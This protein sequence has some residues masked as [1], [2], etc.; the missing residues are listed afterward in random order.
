MR[1]WAGLRIFSPEACVLLRE[2][3]IMRKN[4]KDATSERQMIGGDRVT[5]RGRGVTEDHSEEVAF[6]G[7]PESR[8]KTP[9]SPPTL[10]KDKMTQG[11]VHQ[12]GAICQLCPR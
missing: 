11:L 1:S 8:R 9:P 10:G 12:V 3:Q 7:R 5:S 6:A 2:P 4:I